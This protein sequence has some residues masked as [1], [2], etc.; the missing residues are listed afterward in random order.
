M[1]KIKVLQL[2]IAAILLLCAVFCQGQIKYNGESLFIKSR[3]VPCDTVRCLFLEIVDTSSMKTKW[4]K[5]YVVRK[6]E[7]I[8]FGKT[9]VSENYLPITSGIVTSELF[10]DDKNKVFNKALQVVLLK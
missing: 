9:T 6:N 2:G 5:G 7:M 1:K 3:Y 10:Y 4:T 8:S